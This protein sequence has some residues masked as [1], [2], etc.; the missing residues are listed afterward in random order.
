V[1]SWSSDV[2]SGRRALVSVA[3]AL[4]T[5]ATTATYTLWDN[6]GVDAL[7]PVLYSYGLDIFR[8]AY[9]APFVLATAAGRAAVAGAWREQRRALL[10]I[11]GLS[12]AAYML[13]LVALKLAPVSY[14]AP[15]R[16]ISIVFGALMGAR[17]LG[18][19][20]AGRRVA[21][22]ATIVAGVFLLAIG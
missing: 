19:P 9:F 5:G 14:V 21:G 12:P 20:D 6:R 7:T 4:A 15:A 3:F 10:A 11:G 18:E 1:T 8:T 13:V 22:A 17:L 16:E 2:A